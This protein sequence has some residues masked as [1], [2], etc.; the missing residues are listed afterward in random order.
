MPRRPRGPALSSQ[1]LLLLRGVV[2]VFKSLANAGQAVG[3]FCLPV[4]PVSFSGT[5]LPAVDSTD[6]HSGA[7]LPGGGYD[8]PEQQTFPPLLQAASETLLAVQAAAGRQRPLDPA[9]LSSDAATARQ[10]CTWEPGHHRVP[11]RNSC[12]NLGQ[13]LG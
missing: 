8:E 11:K 5:S 7:G 3:L 12:K 2:V 4:F 1:F 9:F 6:G 13:K 10:V